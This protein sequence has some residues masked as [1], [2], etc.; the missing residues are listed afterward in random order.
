MRFIVDESTGAGVVGLLRLHDES[1]ANRIRVV[2]AVLAQHA[3]QLA[4]NFTMATDSRVRIRR[5][6]AHP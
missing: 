3:G 6:G 5:K 2:E 4:G 1:A